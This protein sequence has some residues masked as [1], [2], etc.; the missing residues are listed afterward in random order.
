M[1][2][3]VDCNRSDIERRLGEL[4]CDLD[5]TYFDELNDEVFPGETAAVM[6]MLD[7]NSLR[8]RRF[9]FEPRISYAVVGE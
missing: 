4:G 3:T 7:V 1:K 2:I 9:E 5:E 8:V 6:E